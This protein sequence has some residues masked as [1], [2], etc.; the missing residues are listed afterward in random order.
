MDISRKRS[1]SRSSTSN[2]FKGL[3]PRSSSKLNQEINREKE[4]EVLKNESLKNDSM[5]SEGKVTLNDSSFLTALTEEKPCEDV[6]YLKTRI[7]T[8]MEQ[9]DTV[10]E[11]KARE[12]ERLQDQL[13]LSKA[14]NEKWLSRFQ[15]LTKW[16]Q[17]TDPELLQIVL[18]VMENSEYDEDYDDDDTQSRA[19]QSM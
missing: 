12:K 4:N 1:L 16:A 8:L 10:M 13:D 11:D 19:D 7:E 3:R 14:E 9:L 6:N 17:D 15:R 18:G 5:K 2:S